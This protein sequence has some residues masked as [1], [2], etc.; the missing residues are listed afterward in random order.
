ME[1]KK[2]KYLPYPVNL[3]SA[4]FGSQLSV[5]ILPTDWEASLVYALN[6][7]NSKQRS[8]VLLSYYKDNAT[9]TNIG[10]TYGLCREAVRQIAGEGIKGLRHPETLRILRYG[11][12]TVAIMSEKKLGPFANSVADLRVEELRLSARGLNCLKR[13]NILTIGQLLRHSEA[14]LLLIPNLG[15]GTLVEIKHSL[16]QKNLILN[17]TPA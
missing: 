8:T 14:E 3:W 6:S 13:A 2:Y 4:I 7:L 9:W 16:A 12:K 17:T 15:K 10:K 1:L 5:E 11:L